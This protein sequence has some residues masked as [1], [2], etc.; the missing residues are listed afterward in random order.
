[1]H[2]SVMIAIRKK[3]MCC[4]V[5]VMWMWLKRFVEKKEITGIFWMQKKCYIYKYIVRH[6]HTHKEYYHYD[7]C[8]VFERLFCAEREK[9]SYY[10]CI[11]I[12]VVVSSWPNV[13][14]VPRV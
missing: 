1:M 11:V 7:Y 8:K 2:A 13:W 10:A 4:V 3:T 6:A 9:E 5:C 14:Q 12:L